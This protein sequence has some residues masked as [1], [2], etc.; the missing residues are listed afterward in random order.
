MKYA[1]FLL[2]ENNDFHNR[3]L[4]I[5]GNPIKSSDIEGKNSDIE[6][7]NSDIEPIIS[8]IIFI[9]RGKLWKNNY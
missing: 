6:S 2:N 8:D 1:A 3:Y 7:G 4:H 9:L 5:S